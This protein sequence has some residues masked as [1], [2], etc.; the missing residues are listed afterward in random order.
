[1]SIKLASWIATF[2]DSYRPKSLLLTRDT[3][4]V[5]LALRKK[6]LYLAHRMINRINFPITIER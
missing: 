2:V 3:K 1:M 5:S 4:I 6:S